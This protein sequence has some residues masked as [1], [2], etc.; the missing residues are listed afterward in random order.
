MTSRQ[1][2][3]PGT[4]GRSLALPEA[5]AQKRSGTNLPRVGGYNQ[6]VVLDAIRQADGVSRVELA[7]Q[8]GLTT[9]TVSNIVRRLLSAGLV[10]ET[11]RA[12]SRGGKRRTLLTIRPDAYF[13]VGV[14]L[15]PDMAVTALVD[16]SGRV[17]TRHRRRLPAAADPDRLVPAVTRAVDRVVAASG[18]ARRRVL[19]LGVAVPGPLDTRHGLVV[20]PPNLAG[21]HEV[22]LRDAVGAATGLPTVVD[23]DATA[24]A[25]GER[26]AGGADRAGS[27]LFLYLGTGIGAGI[28]YWD[29]VL[30]GDT[31]NAGE[32]G[33]TVVV[34]DGAPCRCGARGCLEAHCSPAALVADLVERHGKRAAERLGLSLDPLRVR[35]DHGT[36]CRAARDGD[37]AAR[38]TVALAARRIGQA[39]LTAVN[40]LDV[41][42]IVL[43]GDALR[44]VTDLV[45]AE[46]DRQVNGH[47]I[48]RRVRTV[49]IEPSLVGLDA[50]AVGAASLVLH[51][52]YAPGW[53]MLL[54]ES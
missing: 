29:R 28:V 26:W 38:D 23:N 43:G 49:A 52:T 16:L 19:G 13:S 5:A 17:V 32:F 7:G 34:P 18:I 3:A 33:H 1:R 10:A 37:P 47:A 15:D 40:L 44:G 12:P 11:G 54:A 6:A 42:R 46:I 30:R 24:A 25:V 45:I 4:P 51:G 48:A 50:G 31:G 39:A 35:V 36:L 22:A 20:E 53:R 21:W 41:S 9:Q 8:T 27:F 2:D 14:H